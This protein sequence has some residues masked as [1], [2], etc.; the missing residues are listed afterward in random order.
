MTKRNYVNDARY[1]NLK[2]ELIFNT[3]NILYLP[4]SKVLSKCYTV[5]ISYK[6][7]I[8]IEL[9]ISCLK[10]IDDK[11]N[12]YTEHSF[13]KNLT[14]NKIIFRNNNVPRFKDSNV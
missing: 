3:K 11:K 7:D 13:Y 12:K 4:F 9:F 1:S 2:S 14:K 6:S 10:D 5:L 8:D